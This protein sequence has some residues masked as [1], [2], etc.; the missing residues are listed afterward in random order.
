M[1]FFLKKKRFWRTAPNSYWTGLDLNQGPSSFLPMYL[2]L[3]NYC[4]VLRPFAPATAC[5]KY[6]ESSTCKAS[7][8]RL[9]NEGD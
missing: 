5:Q 2:Y 8:L 3:P 6:S 4:Y 7:Y 9:F 1:L